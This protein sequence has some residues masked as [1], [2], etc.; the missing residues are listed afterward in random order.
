MSQVTGK[1]DRRD[2]RSPVETGGGREAWWGRGFGESSQ[3]T[4]GCLRVSSLVVKMALFRQILT[5]D[6]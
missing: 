4:Q 5:S 3:G 1:P 2:P 6:S